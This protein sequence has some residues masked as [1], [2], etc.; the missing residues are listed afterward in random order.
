MSS[1]RQSLDTTRSFRIELDWRG[2]PEPEPEYRMLDP[3]GSVTIHVGEHRYP[4]SV[5]FALNFW[6][7][8]VLGQIAEVL[9]DPAR[10]GAFS[11]SETGLISFR[12][13]GGSGILVGSLPEGEDDPP[14]PTTILVP[15]R[16]FLDEVF[17]F[18][19]KML[20]RI[21]AEVPQSLK[22][23]SARHLL[24]D[25]GRLHAALRTRNLPTERA[26]RIERLL[27]GA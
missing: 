27:G 21:R 22:G 19:E 3:D 24:A 8:R 15:L 20:M 11:V 9:E 1:D 5:H 26:A 23:R 12:S 13:D 17:S 25:C 6:F 16:E 4:E 14:C 10:A 18:Y 7:G 2:V